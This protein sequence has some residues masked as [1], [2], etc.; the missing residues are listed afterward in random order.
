MI[1]NID[2]NNKTTKGKVLERKWKTKFNMQRLWK[3]VCFS[4][5]EQ[6]FYAGKNFPDPVRCPEC[7]KIKKESKN[8]G[9]NGKKES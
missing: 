3:R 2:Q 1:N 4:A 6:E 5:G 9:K 8:N 7:R